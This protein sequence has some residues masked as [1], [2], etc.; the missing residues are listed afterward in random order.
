MRTTL[1]G[2]Y[3]AI[4]VSVV[5]A[6]SPQAP[7]PRPP[8]GTPPAAQPSKVRSEEVAVELRG[9]MI[10]TRLQPIAGAAQDAQAGLLRATEFVLEGPRDLL[11]ML[12]RDHQGHEE[13]ISGIAIL[14]PSPTNATVDVKTVKR[15]RTTIIGGVRESG[16]IDRSPSLSGGDTKTPV[17]VRVQSVEHVAENCTPKPPF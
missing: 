7:V 4:F 5:S 3:V 1:T 9:C 10:G 2:L 13:T 14:P 15:R 17:R 16:S 8:A 11:Q 6:T 12:A